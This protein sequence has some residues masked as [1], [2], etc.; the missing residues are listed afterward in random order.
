MNSESILR[1]AAA[2]DPFRQETNSLRRITVREMEEQ[3]MRGEKICL[4]R[5]NSHRQEASAVPDSD[6]EPLY[7]ESDAAYV[8]T[9]SCISTASST[10][11]E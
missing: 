3:K 8:G 6:D 10:E 2:S 7:A 9:S 1:L 4:W 11:S 5:K